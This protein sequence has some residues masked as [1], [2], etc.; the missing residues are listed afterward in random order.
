MGAAFGLEQLKKLDANLARRRRIFERYT[1]YFSGHESRFVQP[2]QLDGLETAWLGY[3]LIIRSDAGFA[4][5]D[6]QRFLDGKGIDTR[7]IWTGNVA[8]Q[9]MLRDRRVVLP[10]DGLPNADVVMQRGVL[11]PL[12]H[13]IDDETLDFVIEQLDAFLAAPH[14]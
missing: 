12:S 11:L 8:R 7:T 1:E 9:P 2:R 3:P 6:M 14:G 13:A 4:R 10:D 5:P